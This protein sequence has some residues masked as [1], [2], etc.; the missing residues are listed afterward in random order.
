LYRSFILFFSLLAIYYSGFSQTP[1]YQTYGVL[2]VYEDARDVLQTSNGGFVISGWISDSTFG[3]KDIYVIRTSSIG[4]TIWTK[5][6]GKPNKNDLSYSIKPTY[7]GGYILCGKT[8]DLMTTEYPYLIK[9]DDQGN[10]V[11]SNSFDLSGFHRG[12]DVYPTKDK[13]FAMIGITGNNDDIFL[14]KTDSLGNELW[15]K[16]YGGSNVESAQTVQQTFDG[17]FIIGGYTKTFFGLDNQIYIVKTDS[18]GNE[19]WNKTFKHILDTT[20]T[21]YS[22]RQTIDSGYIIVSDGLY[23]ASTANHID[24]IRTDKN[25]DLLWL[26]TYGDGVDQIARKCESIELTMLSVFTMYI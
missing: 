10:E 24:I 21:L 9:I 5:R 19:I 16:T 14:I 13:G 6:I 1:F 11:W 7:D 25:G 18:M 22:I 26:K 4:D 8:G 2:G 23:H 15:N 20:S 3:L 17:G 12:Y